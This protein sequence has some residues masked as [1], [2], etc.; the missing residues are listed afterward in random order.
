MAKGAEPMTLRGLALQSS[1]G[2]GRSNANLIS[3]EQTGEDINYPVDAKRPYPKLPSKKSSERYESIDLDLE[4]G[5][6]RSV[7]LNI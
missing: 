3:E 4:K 7:I 1:G 2:N 6:Y 5:I